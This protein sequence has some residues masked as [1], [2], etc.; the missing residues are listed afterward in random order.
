MAKT[1]NKDMGDFKAVMGS[2]GKQTHIS[3]G[4]IIKKD[5]KY[6]LLDRTNPP[7]GFAGPAGHMNEKQTVEQTLIKEVK[8]ETGLDV[9]SYKLLFTEEVEWNVCKNGNHHY[10]YVFEC[11]TSGKLK[12]EYHE[13]HS[14]DWYSLRE[15]K[16]LKL[17]PVWEYWFKKLEVLE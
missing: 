1:Y 2:N 7:L 8:E 16:S 10:W 5:S 9:D 11:K 17:E 3:V 13:Y 4:A 6:L 15:V 12:K 14:I